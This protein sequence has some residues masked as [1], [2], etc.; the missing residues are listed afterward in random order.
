MTAKYVPEL[1]C[2][3]RS[4]MSKLGDRGLDNIVL[5]RYGKELC[6]KRVKTH[7]IMVPMANGSQPWS[8]RNGAGSIPILS[9]TIRVTKAGVQ[10]RVVLSDGNVGSRRE[11][12]LNLDI[13]EG[14][15]RR[16]I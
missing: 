12:K 16:A 2:F 4:V 15:R 9:H 6:V 7:H 3:I 1:N 8:V 11:L 14:E 13:P 5:V 10:L